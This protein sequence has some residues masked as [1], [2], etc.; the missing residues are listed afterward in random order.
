MSQTVHVT[1]PNC[2]QVSAAMPG[3]V[4]TCP[5]CSQHM[6]TPPATAPPQY[7]QQYQQQ[8]QAPQHAPIQ[9]Q[10][11]LQQQVPQQYPGRPGAGVQPAPVVG[12]PAPPLTGR[13]KALLIGINYKGTRSELRGCVNDVYHI[14]SFLL[15][16]GF[17]ETQDTLVVL[18]DDQRDPNYLPT[19][20][21]IMNAMGW[22][23]R[24]AQ[25]GDI[26]FWHFSGHGAQEPD[27]NGIEEDG[28][29]E[30]IVPLDFKTAGQIPDNDIFRAL[31]QPLPSGVRLTAIM[32]CC[33]SGTGLDLPWTYQHGRSQTIFREDTNPF[34]S[35]GDV[36]LFSGCED[37]QTSADTQR[38]VK[39]TPS[40][41]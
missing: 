32:D 7:P 24:G 8:Y 18:T 17:T 9:Q 35:L 29:N 1:C 23:S 2:H 41:F 30:T 31:V 12:G 34:H 38:Y 16:N 21:N 22:L 11:Q 19:K 15:A 13:R 4:V 36:Q 6:Q 3:I 40:H 5:F 26:L 28:M 39:P 33:H 27:K 14:K 20:M 10:Q 37:D 25:P